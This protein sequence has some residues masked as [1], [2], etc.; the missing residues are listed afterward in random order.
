[1]LAA[2][3]AVVAAVFSREHDDYAHLLLVAF[4]EEIVNGLLDFPVESITQDKLQKDYK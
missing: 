1:M 4:P 3:V 2:V